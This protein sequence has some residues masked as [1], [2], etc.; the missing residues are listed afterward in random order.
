MNKSLEKKRDDL[1]W[2]ICEGYEETV[3]FNT[4]FDLGVQAERERSQKLVEILEIYSKMSVAVNHWTSSTVSN[5]H[6]QQT[7]DVG[8]LARA[9]LQEY[10]SE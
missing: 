4:G 3:K 5:R 10:R 8:Q 7:T 9:A 6:T 2:N 1:A